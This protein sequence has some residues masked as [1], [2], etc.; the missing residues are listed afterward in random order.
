M[1]NR[2]K[3]PKPNENEQILGSSKYKILGTKI[4]IRLR[5]GTSCI[6]TVKFRGGIWPFKFNFFFSILTKK[7]GQ[8]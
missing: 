1:Y 2:I 6:R 7:S 8:I 4:I 5:I 3:E